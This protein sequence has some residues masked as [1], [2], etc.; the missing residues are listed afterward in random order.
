[1][2]A[3]AA[4]LALAVLAG[5]ACGPA[6]AADTPSVILRTGDHSG[7]GRV[8]FDLPRG[9]TAE[10]VQDGDRLVVRFTPPV[11]VSAAGRAPRNV[12]A[13]TGASGQ[14]ELILAPGAQIRRMRLDGRLVVDFLDPTSAPRPPAAAAKPPAPPR[15]THTV[16]RTPVQSSAKLRVPI[17]MD[18]H[19]DEPAAP[20][21]VATASEPAGTAPVATV[22]QTALPESGAAPGAPS[23][24]VQ[25][26]ATPTPLPAGV[27]GHAA[28]LPFDTGVGAAAFRRGDAALVVFDQR[29][30]IDMAALRGDPAFAAATI[31]LLPAATVLRLPLTPQEGLS[32]TRSAA[33]WTIAT[34]P[35]AAADGGAR[36]IR[37]DLADGVLRL[38]AEA[39]GQVVSVSDP[40][41][42][43]ALL[44]GTQRQPGQS[45]PVARRT[46]EFA[47]LRTWQ[48]VAVEPVSDALSVRVT[49][50]GFTIEAGAGRALALA[51]P[52]PDAVASADAQH[53]S[54]RF[55]F[56]AQPTE[57][58]LR[59]LQA[60]VTAAAAAPAQ[61]RAG[62]RV[63]VAQA[64]L[65]LGMGAEA[66]AT[67]T[68]AATD[69]A[70]IAD[71]PDTLGLSAIAALMAGRAGEAGGIT[72]P[73]L[74]G[75]DEVALWRA[76]R[77]AMTREGA[78]DAAAVFAANL[79]LLLS[80]PAA[81]RNRLLPLAA[82]TIAL[83]GEPAMLWPLLAQRRD[84]TS[85]DLARAFLL[86][87]EAQAPGGDP[88]PAL[89]AY[90]RVAGGPDRLARARA[91]VRAVELRLATGALTSAQAADAL[92]KLL[93][94]WRGDDREL[95]LRQR[96]AEL[97]ARDG[98]FRPAL[99]LLRE[100]EQIWPEQRPALHARLAAIFADALAAD[101]KTPPPPLDLVA[102]VEENADLIADGEAGQ[103]LAARLADRLTAL[104]LP[105]RAVPVLEKL[106]TQ[107][108]AGAV[109]AA[110][111]GRLAKAR[112]EEGDPAGA[113]AALTRSAAPDLPAPLQESRTLTF[114][115][116]AAVSGDLP[117]ATAALAALGTTPAAALRADLLEAA[118]DWPAAL[119]ALRELAA[120][121]VPPEGPLNEAQAR[122]LLRLAAAAAQTGDEATLARL[123][124][125]DTARLPDDKLA[126]M[127]R[128]LTAGPVQGVADLPR[129]AQETKLA[130]ALPAALKTLTP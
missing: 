36:P 75:T 12:Q 45:V 1:M 22:Q 47:L 40:D 113:L 49:A 84:D 21:P 14:A 123:R 97:R 69:D 62:K 58:L 128:L 117:S 74:D 56:P 108:P 103:A 41:T 96:I 106:V 64:M 109:R 44:V 99:A 68:M 80:Y 66:Q 65:A 114:A 119:A 24:P 129:A 6:A 2:R 100:S 15:R 73:R 104:D 82:E 81:M 130:R 28:S 29:R 27:A 16:A 71:N 55:A 79:P 8:V 59:R 33:G 63:A 13:M 31:Q 125:H 9:T 127:F 76:V 105:K 3:A 11:P 25:L 46:P 60:A 120:R 112:L 122:T 85:L 43:G 98:G 61:A 89:D 32:L 50:Q 91:A 18:R 38:V 77:T 78:A 102:L 42:G 70:R 30:P 4:V 10:P 48:G 39:P 124:E 34:V 94:S 54:R 90:D 52:A 116:A 88:K 26:A 35:V 5:P 17:P 111:G 67:L 83:G 57:M 92:D 121:T 7:F 87:A 19:T 72:D 95:A 23:G 110:F 51:A 101:A 37:P 126:E 53:F 107:A 115:R 93:F 20:P 86:E 118:K